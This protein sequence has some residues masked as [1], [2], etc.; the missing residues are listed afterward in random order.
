VKPA[1]WPERDQPAP[2]SGWGRR[3]TVT[4]R[5]HFNLRQISASSRVRLDRRIRM[6]YWKRFALLGNRSPPGSQPQ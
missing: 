6:L 2:K 5:Q 3:R 1:Y 4:H